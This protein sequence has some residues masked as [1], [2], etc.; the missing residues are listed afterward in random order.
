MKEAEEWNNNK[1]ISCRYFLKT[2]NEHCEEKRE[3]RSTSPLLSTPLFNSCRFSLT[4]LPHIFHFY[5]PPLSTPLT[6]LSPCLF[7]TYLPFPAS[8]PHPISGSLLNKSRQDNGAIV[9]LVQ[10]HGAETNAVYQS[11]ATPPTISFITAKSKSDLV[12]ECYNKLLS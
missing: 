2:H 1:Y 9:A 11:S 8:A 4:P 5:P 6:H 12:S 10:E 7:F 3:I